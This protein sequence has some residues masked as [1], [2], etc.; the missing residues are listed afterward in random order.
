MSMLFSEF[1]IG[2]MSVKNRIVMP[3]MVM[4]RCN[5]HG[6]PNDFHFT[7]YT[8]R[9]IGGVGLIIVEATAVEARGRITDQD[10]GIWDDAHI[11][12]HAKINKLCHE[13]GAKTALQIA[14][15]GRKSTASESMPIAPSALRF[16]DEGGF[17][18]PLEMNWDD[19]QTLRQAFVK[20]ALRAEQAGYDAIELHAAHGYLIYEFLS[21]LTNK[22]MDE[23]GKDFEG[24]CAFVLEIVKDIK[25]YVSL[26]LIVRISADEWMEGG[27]NVED[28]V[29]L[30]KKLK[31]AGVDLMHVSAGGNHAVQ[32][33]MPK[34]VPMY[35]ADYAKA[36]REGA[37]IPTIAVGLITTAA[38]GEKLL[39]DEA[40]DMVAYG[41]ELLRNPNFAHH[42]A[43]EFG[44]TA[45]IEPSHIR[46]F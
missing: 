29:K 37:N 42:A 18:T 45:T 19:I 26:P 33:K 16:A 13:F 40:C 44:E 43:K 27:W 36:V 25:K 7:H 6:M 3:P 32:T 10:M 8:A 9:A 24:R 14:H 46:A 20:A 39:Q 35:Q 21:P 22:R 11:D 17:K 23:Y 5:D 30:A 28:T 1:K 15:A 38:D 41:R 31:E 34:L 4:Y 2:D 12:G